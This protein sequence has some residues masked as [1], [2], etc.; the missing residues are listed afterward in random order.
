[1]S[2]RQ[3]QP[4]DDRPG[5]K[6]PLWPVRNG[7]LRSTQQTYRHAVSK[8]SSHEAAR[9]TPVHHARASST[10]ELWLTTV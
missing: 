7:L 4:S 3:C 9:A 1:M 5:A 8:R 2:D 6:G 10:G